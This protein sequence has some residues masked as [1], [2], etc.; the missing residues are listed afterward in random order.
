MDWDQPYIKQS[1]TTKFYL[2]PQHFMLSFLFWPSNVKQPPQILGVSQESCRNFT[3]KT[4]EEEIFPAFQIVPYFEA[5]EQALLRQQNRHQAG[6]CCHEYDAALL[7]FPCLVSAPQIPTSEPHVCLGG[8]V[9]SSCRPLKFST[10]T[11]VFVC[12][13][14]GR[15]AFLETP[16]KLASSNR[17][18]QIHAALIY[19]F[20]LLD[21]LTSCVLLQKIS[22]HPRYRDIANYLHSHLQLL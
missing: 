17:V 22:H 8:D 1:P 12:L 5:P 9:P 21:G 3:G 18:L 15:P 2:A 13:I 10:G 20:L 14:S 7:Y 19:F 4:Q 11:M 6:K 16:R